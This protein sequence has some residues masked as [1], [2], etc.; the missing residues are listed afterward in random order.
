M[1][2]SSPTNA[3]PLQNMPVWN[4]L[5]GL[6][7]LLQHIENEYSWCEVWMSILTILVAYSS[8]CTWMPPV[9]SLAAD[10][11]N[12]LLTYTFC[13]D[14]WSKCP[15]LSL[16]SCLVSCIET[17]DVSK[18]HQIGQF[19]RQVRSWLDEQIGHVQRMAMLVIE[20]EETVY[21]LHSHGGFLTF[22][23]LQSDHISSERD[24][25]I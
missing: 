9:W 14:T 21:Y 15:F 17:R 5:L 1:G 20:E 16:V 11:L 4:G 3:V 10:L 7:L 22:C 24:S 8:K 25:Y 12:V 13:L 6:C 18:L 23:L 2:H 19:T